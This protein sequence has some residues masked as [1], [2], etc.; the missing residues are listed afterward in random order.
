MS[1][2]EETRDGGYVVT[3]AACSQAGSDGTYS[4]YKTDGQGNLSWKTHL[5]RAGDYISVKETADGGHAVAASAYAGSW[6]D[7]YLVKLDALGAVVWE[8][9]YGGKETEEVPLSLVAARDGGFIL[10]GSIYFPGTNNADA[11]VVR[12]DAEGGLL[13]EKN[14]GGSGSDSLIEAEDGGCLLTI[15]GNDGR[16]QIDLVKTDGR[17]KVEWRQFIGLEFAPSLQPT[18]DGGFILAGGSVRVDDFGFNWDIQLA[19]ADGQGGLLWKKD[20]G[21][22]KGD[23]AYSVFPTRDGG[24]A[25]AG[26]TFSFGAGAWDIYILKTDAEGGLLWQ[27]TI[28]TIKDG[29]ESTTIRETADGGYI[30]AGTLDDQVYLAKL[31]PDGSGPAASRFRRGD[32]N[33]DGSVDL[34]DPIS[35]LEWMFLGRQEASCASAADANDDGALDLSDVIAT[36]EFLFSGSGVLPT[37]GPYLC[38]LGVHEAELGCLSYPLCGSR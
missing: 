25:I 38:G 24:Y 34:S 37:P 8:R 36:L 27:K 14:L 3:G 33:V 2:L 30:L 18:L 11:Y 32:S 4:L 22:E 26:N 5:T 17:G 9:T 28:G 35:T 12:T 23:I 29:E 10:G 20:L 15:R 31:G 19:K 7:F 16:Q 21:G 1:S 13:W 6:R